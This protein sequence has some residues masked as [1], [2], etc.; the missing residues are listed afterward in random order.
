M[1][2]SRYHFPTAVA[3]PWGAG[4]KKRIN[5]PY[6]ILIHEPHGAMDLTVVA[7]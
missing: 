4:G 5:F 6:L 1:I 3:S 7:I 2:W